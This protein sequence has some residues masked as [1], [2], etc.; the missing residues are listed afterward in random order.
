MFATAL[1]NAAQRNVRIWGCSGLG[2]VSFIQL[3]LTRIG[4]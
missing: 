3:L 2:G 1:L 4:Q